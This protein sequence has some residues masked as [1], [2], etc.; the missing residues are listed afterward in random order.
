MSLLNDLGFA[1]W[2]F[3]ISTVDHIATLQTDNQYYK[4]QI[5]T[6]YGIAHGG[7]Y[8]FPYPSGFTKS[9]CVI[10]QYGYLNGTD[11]VMN[12]GT[13]AQQTDNGVTVYNNSGYTVPLFAVF[14]HVI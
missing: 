11:R 3:V 6:Q 7:S 8:A 2:R 1:N 13:S 4:P 5:S 14:Q 10:V 12:A 9:N